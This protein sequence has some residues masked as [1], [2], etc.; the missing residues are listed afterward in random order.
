VRSWIG[1][2]TLARVLGALAARAVAGDALPAVLNVAA[3]RPAA[4]ADLLDAAAVPW[5]FGPPTP[6][7]IPAVTFDT[8]LLQSLV[9]LPAD[10]GEP[11]ALVREWR[12]AR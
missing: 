3:P 4:M 11:A 6:A 8:G 10:A 9:A 5:R 7:V 12:A 2:V 1:P